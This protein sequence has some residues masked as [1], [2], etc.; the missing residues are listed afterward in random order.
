MTNQSRKWVRVILGAAMLWTMAGCANRQK[1]S[2]MSGEAGIASESGESRDASSTKVYLETFDNGTNGWFD[3]LGVEP[4]PPKPLT[5]KNGAVES[6]SPWW[7]D[8]NHAPPGGGYLHLI[9]GL[10]TNPH[11]ADAAKEAAGANKF[12]VGGF[13]KDFTNARLTIR[14]KGELDLRG[15]QVCL[16]VQGMVGEI[17]AGWVLTGQPIK[18]TKDWSVQTIT[19]VYDPKQWTA[20]GSRHDR[21]DTYGVIDLKTILSDVNINLYIVLFPLDVVPNAKIQGDPHRLRAGVDY[22]ADES[23]LPK[24]CIMI[25]S[26]KIEFP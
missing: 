8:F 23:K 16:L 7:V 5:L 2:A 13:P 20:L 24:G 26:V 11:W 18:L 15:A 1:P 4:F 21:T 9:M 12:V 25:D 6:C 14:S 19:A 10:M 22:V 17:C 3:V